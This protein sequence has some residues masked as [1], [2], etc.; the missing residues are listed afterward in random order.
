MK[1]KK[2]AATLAMAGLAFATTG[3]NAAATITNSDGALS[4]FGGFDW[5]SGAVAWTDGFNGSTGNTFSLFYAGWATDVLK[6]DGSSLLPLGSLLDKVTDGV[7]NGGPAQASYE[8]TIFASIQEKVDVCLATSCSFSILGG[9]YDIYYNVKG[10]GLGTA[11]Q[12]NNGV[13]AW[14]GFKDGTKI[15]S[16]SFDASNASQIFATSGND[17]SNSTTLAGS[18]TYTNLAY[19]NPVLI[20]TNVTSTLQLGKSKTANVSPVSIDGITPDVAGGQIVFQADANQSFSTVPEPGALALV[21]L[22]LAGC[23]LISRRKRA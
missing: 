18:V 5:A 6:P 19:V 12:T 11:V 21:G 23:G 15:I 17:G 8:Y 1:L 2:L 9:S 7:F 10:D 20:G 3:A 16:G 13:G 4:P 22:A 14:T